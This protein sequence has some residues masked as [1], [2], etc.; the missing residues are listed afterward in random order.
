MALYYSIF[1]TQWGWFGILGD[2]GAVHRTCLP[3]RSRRAVQI[4]LLAGTEAGYEPNYKKAIQK[5]IQEYFEGKQVDFEAVPVCFKG[6][7][8]FQ[9][10]V[11]LT[12][13]AVRYGERMTY[14]QLAEHAGFGRAARAVGQVAA[15]NPI[16]LIIPCHRIIRSDGSPGG[17]SAQGGQRMKSRMLALEQKG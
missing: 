9:K 5:T 4:S 8:D 12:L 3:A 13:K 15:A 6:L 16:P 10:A 7:T 1:E 14:R 2:Q 17:F 11:L